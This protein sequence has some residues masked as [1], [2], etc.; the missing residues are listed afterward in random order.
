MVLLLSPGKPGARADV[1]LNLALA[2]ASSQPRV[3][4]VDADFKRRDISRRVV[5]G[6]GAGLLEVANGAKLEQAL[7]AETETG[8]MV[9]QAGRDANGDWP[10]NPDS[11][12]RALDQARG[13]YTMVIDG[14]SD[15][16]DP[17]GALLAAAADSVVLV[18]TTGVTRAR[19]IADFQRSADFPTAKVRGVVLVS[20]AAAG[21]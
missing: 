2:T 16:A 9:L 20:G 5:G 18:V 15:P 4:L 1:S 12:R 14:P 10:A 3:L 17:L 8:L 11:I 13:G 6:D 21:L 7:I 19:E